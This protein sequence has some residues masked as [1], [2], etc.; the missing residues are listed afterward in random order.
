MEI[1]RQLGDVRDELYELF[2]TEVTV[3]IRGTG[4]KAGVVKT[5]TSKDCI[6][7]YEKLMLGTAARVQ[8]EH[9][10]SHHHPYPGRQHGTGAGRVSDRCRGEPQKH[11]DWSH[12]RQP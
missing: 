5:G 11:S 6:T 7:D 12:E 2:M 3:G 8:K 4:I 10:S 9:R 1:P